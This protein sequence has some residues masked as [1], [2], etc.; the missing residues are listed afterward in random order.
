MEFGV[1]IH[2]EPGIETTK[3]QKADTLAKTTVDMLLSEYKNIENKKVAL[4]IN[5]FGSTPLSELYI[6][7]R[8]V[9]KVL[10]DK[11]VIVDRTFVGNYMTSLDMAGASISILKLD[12]E[13]TKLLDAPVDVP[14]FSVALVHN[15]IDVQTI[16]NGKGAIKK[17]NYKL[18]TAKIDVNKGITLNAMHYIID[19]MS[20]CIIFNEIKFNDLDSYAGDGDF[21]SSIAKGFR[22]IKDEWGELLKKKSIS[23]FLDSCAIILME[24][25]GGASGP[26]WGGAFRAAAKSVNSNVLS[27]KDFANMMQGA[28]NGIQTVGKKSFGRGA[29]V[30]DKTLIDALVPATNVWIDATKHHNKT[31]KE[32][33][34]LGAKAAVKGAD[35]TKNIVA[36]M[37]RAGNAGERSIGYADAGAKGL[38]EIFKYIALSVE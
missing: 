6:L 37:G 16:L 5:G 28:V 34:A 23:E 22:V 18:E 26:I 13:M 11:K 15:N 19:L 17:G 30:G 32:I 12:A 29:K 35:S 27:I 8:Y 20:N 2:G 9:Q 10:L 24:N 7:N 31:F 3:I 1:G 25:S 36:R 4:L 14:G 33:F 21:G 38:A